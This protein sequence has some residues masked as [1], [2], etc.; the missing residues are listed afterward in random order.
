MIGFGLRAALAAR[1]STTPTVHEAPYAA[2]AE[3]SR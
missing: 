1:R 3:A 2:I